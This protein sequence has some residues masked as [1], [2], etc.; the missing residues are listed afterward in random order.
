M[1]KEKIVFSDIL[2]EYFEISWE[3]DNGYFGQILFYKDKDGNLKVNAETMDKE[4][5]KK[6]LNHLVD[7][8]EIVE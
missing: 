8:T 3:D 2:N 1:K 7:N 5:I 4:F 6:V